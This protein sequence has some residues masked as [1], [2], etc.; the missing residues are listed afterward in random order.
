VI[1]RR[2]LFIAFTVS[3][4]LGGLWITASWRQNCS[5]MAGLDRQGAE[6][7]LSFA[8]GLVD[9]AQRSRDDLA[10]QQI[11]RLVAASPGIS[12]AAVVDA[13]GRFVAHSDPAR[14]GERPPPRWK[15]HHGRVLTRSLVPPG[16]G[17]IAINFST[18]LADYAAHAQT[19]LL[20]LLSLEILS[21]AAFAC[22]FLDIE[23]TR[24]AS[25]MQELLLER[26]ES[27][28]TA[29]QHEER[30]LETRRRTLGWIQSLITASAMPL[31]VLDDRQCL[32][33]CHPEGAKRLGSDPAA[34][35]GKSWH[36][37][38]LLSSY[39]ALLSQSL[40]APG[41]AVSAPSENDRVPNKLMTLE[42]P[43]GSPITLLYWDSEG[44]RAAL[45]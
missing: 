42:G 25:R 30:A 35:L 41:R 17:G 22:V 13:G 2:M 40:E 29:Q 26:D 33:A 9:D 23:R 12:F 5:S 19:R 18:R 10:R 44:R 31:A 36:E 21:I 27:R 6:R 34:L 28:R 1:S 11:V 4:L 32:I 16:S 8:A 43:S 3:V 15:G 24:L 45:V 14:L 37:I 7:F 39:G 20:I 38:G